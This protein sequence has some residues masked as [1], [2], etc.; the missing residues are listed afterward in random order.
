MKIDAIPSFAK[1][2]K[3]LK[4]KYRSIDSD[5]KIFIESLL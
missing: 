2:I 1:D 5:F 4:K 3:A